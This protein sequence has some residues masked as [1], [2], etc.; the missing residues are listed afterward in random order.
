MG[1]NSW[2]AFALLAAVLTAAGTFLR[3][4]LPQLVEDLKQISQAQQENYLQATEKICQ[5]NREENDQWRELHQ[6]H[7]DQLLGEM[8]DLHKRLEAR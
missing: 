1:E 4:W 3:W 2:T 7:H 6:R 8:K 5:H